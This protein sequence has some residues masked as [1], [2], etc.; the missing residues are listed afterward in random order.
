VPG[1]TYK[2]TAHVTI[3]NQSC[4]PGTATGPSPSAT[5][6]LPTTPV[7]IDSSITV[8]DTNG[9]SFDFSS[10]GSQLYDQSFACPSTPGTHTLSNTATISS[11]GQT[12]SAQATVE[13]HI[14]PQS[15]ALARPLTDELNELG[16][17]S[18]CVSFFLDTEEG[19]SCN[20]PCDG[21]PESKDHHQGLA[22]TQQLADG[23]IYFFLSHSEVSDSNERGLLA[24][25]RYDGTTD[26]GHVT[27]DGKVATKVQFH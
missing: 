17:N 27:E 11:T 13:C 23:S 25:F 10:S 20:F 8:T 24:Q 9:K 4:C 3:T 21:T 12:A 19:Q 5:V 2:V 15:N 1:G 22:R 16:G 18:S 6:A 7:V 14:Y 26:N